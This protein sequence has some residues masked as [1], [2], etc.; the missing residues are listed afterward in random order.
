MK[1]IALLLIEGDP[2]D[3]EHIRALMAGSWHTPIDITGVDSLSAAV[4]H[5]DGGAIDII[6]TDLNLPDSHGLDIVRKI[7]EKTADLPIVVLAGPDDKELMIEAV[8][9]GAQDYLIKGQLDE[10]SLIRSILYLLERHSLIREL[11]EISITDYLTGLYNRHGLMV[12]SQKHLGLA[13]RFDNI[14]W[15]MYLELDNMKWINDNLGQEEC[16]NALIDVAEILRRTFRESD[17]VAR[18]DGNEFVIIAVNEVDANSQQM[19][20]RV[21]ENINNF[22]AKTGRPYKLSA[23]MVLVSHAAVAGYNIKKLLY[24][25]HKNMYEEKSKKK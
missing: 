16:D 18:I 5:L 19:L 22:N 9:S 1:N 2:A 7:H 6:L 23:S 13:T 11:E 24:I 4:E 15:L 12:L 17:V 25:A 20:E 10:D 3:T 14:L 21:R 8:K